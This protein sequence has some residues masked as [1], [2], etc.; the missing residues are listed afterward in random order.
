[1]FF[2]FG[3]QQ[4]F[5]LFDFQHA[6]TSMQDH[7][8]RQTPQQPQNPADSTIVKTTHQERDQRAET[9]YELSSAFLAEAPRGLEAARS[10][11]CCWESLTAEA[12]ATA[13][14]RRSARYPRLAVVL[15]TLL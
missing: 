7:L 6:T 1:M 15:T 5:L 8:L 2:L 12:R 13:A 10:F 14:A 4:L 11:F 3:V 9:L